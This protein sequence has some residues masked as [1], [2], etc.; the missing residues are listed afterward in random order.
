MD[1]AAAPWVPD[2]AAEIARIFDVRGGRGT[3]PVD[4]LRRYLA[5]RDVLIVLDNCEHVVELCAEL[6]GALLTSCAQVRVL[7]T[8]R[9]PLGVGGETVGR[10]E[11]LELEDAYRL[12]VERARQRQPGFVPSEEMNATITRLCARL[13]RL[14]LAIE[15]AAG[16]VGVMTPA[17]VLSGLDIRLGALGGG[18]GS[19]PRHR[20]VRAV[21]EWSYRLLDPEEQ[22]ALRCLAVFVGGFGA[23]AAASVRR[24]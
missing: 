13:D 6:A 5:E 1:L 12:F 2:V 8:S 16:R 24:S 11:P 3:A 10:L 21:V 17:E 18:R 23:D 22:Q 19:P 4:A 20:T 7:A 15:L 14:P 9:E